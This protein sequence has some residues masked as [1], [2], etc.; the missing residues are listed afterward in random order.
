MPQER[1][2]SYGLPPGSN[3][4]EIPAPG[5]PYA[6]A[7]P[8]TWRPKIGLIGCG[9]ITIQHLRAYRAAGYR[10]VM[11]CDRHEERAKEA[12]KN[13]YPEA[14]VCTDFRDVLRRDDVEVVDLAAHPEQRAL[15]YGP[16]IEAGKHILSQKPFV[17]DIDFGERVVEQAEK[18]GVRLA[19]NQNGRWAPHWSWIRQAISAGLLGQVTSVRTAVNWDHNWVAGSVFDRIHALILY[20][21]GIHWFDIVTSFLSPRRAL[22]VFASTAHAPAQK[23]R[24]PLLSQALVEYED[25]QAQLFFDANTLFGEQDAT[26]VSGTLGSAHSTGADLNAQAVTLAT[27]EGRARP[28]LEGQWFPDGFHGTMGE[29]LRSVEEKREPLNSARDNLRSLELCF[30]AIESAAAHRPVVPGTVR[31]LRE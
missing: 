24:P 7:D 2:D 29:L 13:Y 19:V 27:A 14:E 9:G 11:L 16:A 23:A 3:R 28:A 21:F 15:M 18:K 6:P 30:A 5:L 8:R 25:A 17:T 1:D 31:K 22:R 20:D 4:R 12:Q 26:F 10:V